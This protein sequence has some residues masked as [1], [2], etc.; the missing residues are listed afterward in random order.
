MRPSGM[1]RCAFLVAVA[2]LCCFARSGQA[3]LIGNQLAERAFPSDGAQDVFFA[4]MVGMPADGTVPAVSIFYQG[5]S[6]TFNVFQLRP[7]GVPDQF[8]VVYDSGTITSD[9]IA[10]EIVSLPFPNGATDVLAGDIFAHVGRGIPYSDAGALN[11]TNALP[12]FYPVPLTSIPAVGSG[13]TLTI[14]ATGG[15]STAGDFPFRG[16]LIRD[17][18]MSVTLETD[19]LIPGD[20]DGN[21]VVNLDDFGIIRDN[22]LTG[23]TLSEGDLNFDGEVDF[24][25]FLSWKTA[26]GPGAPA[27][28]PE[29]STVALFVVGAAGLAWRIRRTR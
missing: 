20:V 29:P 21:M 25:D 4:N 13:G 26:F 5:T 11:A 9:G 6:G 7:T 3:V 14:S 12:I 8:S 23:S 15:S 17:Y 16:D 27:S 28:V 19:Q 1:L 2:L 10:G 22:F 18:A 24:E